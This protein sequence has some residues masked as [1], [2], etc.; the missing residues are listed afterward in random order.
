MFAR[1]SMALIDML[2]RPSMMNFRLTIITTKREYR[3]RR[4]LYYRWQRWNIIP[5][6]CLKTPRQL[7]KEGIIY[8][9]KPT[10]LLTLTRRS[11][12]ESNTRSSRRARRDSVA[13]GASVSEARCRIAADLT[14][15]TSTIVRK[16][17]YDEIPQL[18]LYD[19]IE[20]H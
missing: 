11:G 5:W 6:W 3:C 20:A 9:N 10:K 18:P 14:I 13:S 12:Q 8:S 2:V 17:C 4:Q 16:S 7:R 1:C 19:C 15:H